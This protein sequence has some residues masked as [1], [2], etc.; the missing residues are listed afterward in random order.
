M[1]IDLETARRE[2]ARPPLEDTGNLPT[3]EVERYSPA[4][5]RS[6]VLRAESERYGGWRNNGNAWRYIFHSNMAGKKVLDY[7]C[8]WGLETIQLLRQ[9]A[10]V[11]YADI[12]RSNVIATG[13]VV[14]AHGLGG[15]GLSWGY[16]MSHSVPAQDLGD[17]DIFYANG[18]IHH[19]PEA[20]QVM[21]WAAKHCTEARLMVYN[22]R[23]WDLAVPGVTMPEGPAITHPDYNLFLRMF[24]AVGMYS[25]CYDRPKFQR[26]IDGLFEITTWQPIG[27][28][29]YT[30]VVLQS[31]NRTT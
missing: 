25:D 21:E 4:Q 24:D 9:G 3:A 2:W 27:E 26:L 7:G 14:M 8:G 31:L 12:V 19:V 6:M 20:R 5:L 13:L 10:H 29:Q 15:L 28:G 17:Y 11:T 1:N 30:A 22:E 23:A 18:V 16:T